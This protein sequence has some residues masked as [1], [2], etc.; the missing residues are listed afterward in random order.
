[1]LPLWLLSALCLFIFGFIA[2]ISFSLLLVP[3]TAVYFYGL[4][5]RQFGTWTVAKQTQDNNR[6]TLE[7]PVCNGTKVIGWHLN[8]LSKRYRRFHAETPGFAFNST[9]LWDPR[10]WHRPTLE[11]IR[12]LET[13]KDG[14]Q[15]SRLTPWKSLLQH[16]F[17]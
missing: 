5:Y 2:A 10:R 17:C 16:N 9:I 11:Q 7:G 8:E 4:C 12:Q 1:M 15:V 3:I 14:F 6:V 13:V